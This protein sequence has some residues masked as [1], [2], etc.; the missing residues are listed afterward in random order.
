MS[1]TM[2]RHRVMARKIA[3]ALLVGSC[4]PLGGCLEDVDV[5]TGSIDR[6]SAN[7]TSAA[8]PHTEATW[9]AYAE[10]WGKRYDENPGEKAASIN[11]AR[12]L[13]AL[14]RN[15]QAVAVMQSAAIKMPKDMEVLGAYGKALAD[16]GQLQQAA[17]V[18]SRSYAPEHPDWSDMSA[19]GAVADR[20]GNHAAAQEYYREALKIAPGEPSILN[21]LGLSY[22]LDKQLKQAEDTLRQAAAQESADPRIRAN[23]ALCLSLEGKF[24][25]AQKTSEYDLPP[26]AAAGDTAAIRQIIVQPNAWRQIELSESNRR[27]RL[28]DEPTL[29]QDQARPPG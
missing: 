4:L 17:D 7:H 22:L 15:E 5:V 16:N 29:P 28:R 27:N 12:A 6:T 10:E 25:E 11:Y 24:A 13:R 14:T 20:L 1:F 21:N 2:A 8:L 9:R 18:L 26:A 23:L 3:M 19:Q